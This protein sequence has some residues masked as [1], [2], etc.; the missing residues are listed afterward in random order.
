[1]SWK[2]T[3]CWRRPRVYRDAAGRAAQ[4]RAISRAGKKLLRSQNKTAARRVF[5]TRRELS[6]PSPNDPANAKGTAYGCRWKFME[7]TRYAIL[8]IFLIALV[9]L[10]LAMRG[11]PFAKPSA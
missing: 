9:A 7:L 11:T 6:K 4:S 2:S 1:M 3:S 5:F 10:S 8:P